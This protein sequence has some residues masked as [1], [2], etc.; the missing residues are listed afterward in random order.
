MS[1][2]GFASVLSVIFILVAVLIAGSIFF[3][4]KKNINIPEIIQQTSP[5]YKEWFGVIATKDGLV[6]IDPQGKLERDSSNKV[7]V[8]VPPWL[9]AFNEGTTTPFVLLEDGQAVFVGSPKISSATT[10]ENTIYSWPVDSSREPQPLLQI[11]EGQKIRSFAISPDYRQAA[12]ISVTRT[13]D[14]I[15]EGEELRNLSLEESK[16][17]LEERTKQLEE[18]LGIVSVYDLKTGAVTNKLELKAIENISRESAAKLIWKKTGLLVL[19]LRELNLFNPQNGQ[20]VDTIEDTSN[21]QG[22]TG[23]L[24]DIILVS[25]DGSKYFHPTESTVRKIPGGEIIAKINATEIVNPDSIDEN[26]DLKQQ[27]IWAGPA[28]F[29][30]DSKKLLFQGRSVTQNNF[31]IWELDLE[32]GQTGKIGDSEILKSGSIPVAKIKSLF[33]FL[34][35][36]PL[37]DRIFFAANYPAGDPAATDLFQLK[38]G[39]QK[40]EFINLFDGIDVSF[41]GWYSHN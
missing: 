11:L 40:A 25:P 36:S 2:K 35:Y 22:R 38:Q 32:S 31:I 13:A 30:E 29:S 26:K 24:R 16:K 7:K 17:I 8:I 10:M 34:T 19:E 12:V 41:S 14:E 37:G 3:V 20:I 9:Q 1:N 23:P 39:E 15:Y 5:S 6:K 27:I 28:A 21:I 33:L 4:F 18:E